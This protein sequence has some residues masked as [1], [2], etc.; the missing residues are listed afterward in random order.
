[1]P[2]TPPGPTG[3]TGVLSR[4]AAPA[5]ACQDR[6]VLAVLGGPQPVVDLLADGAH[7]ELLGVT[8]R[9]PDLAAQGEHRLAGQGA[10]EDLLLAHVV[11]EALVVARFL[12]LFL[13]LL[14]LEHRRRG[15]GRAGIGLALG[16]RREGV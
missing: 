2:G 10:L 15:R 6:S 14:A 5:R 1:M 16:L 12:Q 11:R 8:P 7:G 3:P 9:H 4:V 13:D